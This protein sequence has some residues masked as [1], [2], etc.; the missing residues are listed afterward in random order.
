M[1]GVKEVWLSGNGFTFPGPWQTLQS[2]RGPIG[3]G[4]A[5]GSPVDGTLG[6]ADSSR[7]LGAFS[8]AYFHSVAWHALF[9]QKLLLS[10]PPG[11]S[12]VWQ[13]SH[14]ASNL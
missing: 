11:L 10:L 4:M 5:G 1:S 8:P 14:V 9:E 3:C 6:G 13:A 2:V 12:T 7:T